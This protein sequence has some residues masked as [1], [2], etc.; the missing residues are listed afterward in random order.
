[1]AAPLLEILALLVLR[2]SAKGG[3]SGGYS[4]G[5]SYGGYSSFGGGMMHSRTA[6]ASA[7]AFGAVVLLSA[8][9]R[10]RYGTYNDG[11]NNGVCSLLTEEEMSSACL[12]LMTNAT[13]CHDCIACETEDC[14][15]AIPNCD[16]YLSTV[17][18]E[19]CVEDCNGEGMISSIIVVIAFVLI[20]CCSVAMFFYMMKR[21]SS[22]GGS[23]D[24]H[25]EQYGQPYSQ[26]APYGQPYQVEGN[27][28]GTTVPGTV[29]Q[30]QVIGVGGPPKT[31]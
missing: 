27:W 19:C 15:Y 20:C 17:Y 10:R 28:A 5:G 21:K 29:V 14:M 6:Y 8:G 9:S 1:M 31:A 3:Y 4:G 16:E 18:T 24:Q 23:Q 7:G 25:D 2:A 22:S 12:N 30:G 13:I 11:N 26:P